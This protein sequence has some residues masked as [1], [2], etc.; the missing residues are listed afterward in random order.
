MPHS[1]ATLDLER[2]T[3]SK[4]GGALV[5]GGALANEEAAFKEAEDAEVVIIRWTKITPEVIRRLRRCRAIVRYGIGYDNVDYDAAT[6]AGILMVHVPAYS[7][8]EVATHAFALLLACVRDIVGAHQKIVGG[9]WSENPITRQWR[10]AGR[11]IGLVGFGNIGRSMARKLAGWQMQVLAADPYAP[12]ESAAELGV[13]LVDLETLCRESDC[14]SLHAPLLP[15]TRHLISR[16]ELAWMKPGVILVNTSRG[17]ILDETALA[18]SLTAGHVA[19]AGLDVFEREPLP[20][21]SPLRRHP[22][23]IFSDHAAW[24]SEDSAAELKR[25]VAEEAVRVGTGG[26]PVGIANPEVLHKLGR[27]EEWTPTYN[28]QWR[29]RRAKLLAPG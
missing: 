28:A 22:R 29:A 8:D 17:P 23:V 14:I 2:K 7:V 15:E 3:I 5:D 4:G 24:Y 6:A 21:D 19:A 25:T 1:Y 11:T 12:P 20:L 27:F 18:E 9:G 16:R 13:R 26:L 10:M